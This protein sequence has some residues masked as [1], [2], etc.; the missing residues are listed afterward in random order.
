MDLRALEADTDVWLLTLKTDLNCSFS[1][2]RE[3]K[4][5][6]FLLLFLIFESYGQ[7][8]TINIEFRVDND[9]FPDCITYFSSNGE[10]IIKKPPYFLPSIEGFRYVDPKIMVY[11]DWMT[12]YSAP[13]LVKDLPYYEKDRYWYKEISPE[14]LDSLY[15]A[16]EKERAWI[17]ME[18]FK[19]E[20]G[21]SVSMEFESDTNHSI[22]RTPDESSYIEILSDVVVERT[23][24]E[25][26]GGVN[27]GGGG[28][29]IIGVVDGI[30]LGKKRTYLQQVDYFEEH[31]EVKDSLIK[32]N[33]SIRT[34]IVQPKLDSIL[35]PFYI[36]KTEVTVGEYKQFIHHVRDSLAL[37]RA[38]W[39]A[40]GDVALTLLNTGKST[41]KKIDPSKKEE[42]LNTYG[43][44]MPK[45]F[46][47]DP[48]FVPLTSWIYYPQPARYY[49]RREV[50]NRRI[51]YRLNDSTEINVYPDTTVMYKIET[52]FMD[53]VANMYF[54]HPA[55]DDYP[56]VGLNYDQII[57]YCKWKERQLSRELKPEGYKIEVNIPTLTQYEFAL[58]STQ[59]QLMNQA[60]NTLND[61][62]ITYYRNNWNE[63]QQFL[64]KVDTNPQDIKHANE[65]QYFSWLKGNY[66]AS[67]HF[68][69]G[70]VSE[71]I[72][73]QVDPEFLALHGLKAPH[74]T[75]DYYCAIG[76]NYYMGVKTKDDFQFNALFYKR[77][78]AKGQTDGLTGFRLVYTLIE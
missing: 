63:P 52:A 72:R 10:Y 37:H 7:T 68:L 14:K 53:I 61:E 13:G 73:D 8:D 33:D 67:I 41:R 66:N 9:T 32:Q 75:G 1:Y 35:K 64:K 55:Y 48:M 6:V 17:T 60:H 36:S 27:I 69:N 56:V 42:N 19:R 78:I 40:E 18:D 47:E 65:A 59:N 71:V 39:D 12:L 38:F 49:A 62:L 44:K 58:K 4:F 31:P 54:W 34:Y 46:W 30:Y 24:S 70:N 16:A 22:L 77:L 23:K 45:G 51:K 25:N 29:R 5:M 28:I 57:A 43:L 76:D 15:K 2:I 21:I 20:S 26:I 50:D 11:D 74:N 3:M